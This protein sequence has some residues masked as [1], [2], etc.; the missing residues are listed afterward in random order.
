[1]AP[2]KS[3]QIKSP[4]STLTTKISDLI[5]DYNIPSSVN[6]NHITEVEERMWK[7]EGLEPGLLVLGKR[8]IE[9]LRFPLHPMILQILSTLQVHSIQ[10]T[11]NSLKCILATIILNEVEKKDITVEDFLF[12]YKVVKTPSNPKAPAKQFLTFYLSARKYYVYSGKLSVDKDW[13]NV[14][15]LFVISGDWMS[16]KFDISV[17]PLVNKF[18][19]G[20]L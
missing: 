17:F 18:T 20:K 11:P 16:L 3:I 19:R 10:L 4:P 13:E 1:M 15:G 8:H 2:K 9:T 5:R 6:I 14:G 7:V 12:A